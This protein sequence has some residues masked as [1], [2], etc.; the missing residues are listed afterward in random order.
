M[1]K[2][3]L[4]DLDNLVEAEVVDPST[5]EAIRAYYERQREPS[6]NR[7]FVIFGILGAILVGLGIILIIAHNWDQLPRWSKTA[8]AFLPLV[9]GQ[10][11]CVYVLTKRPEDRAWREAATAFLF[12]SVGACLSLVSQI[13]NI[14]G[15]V[16]DFVFTWMLLCWP[17]VYV[18]GSSTASL[19]YLLGITYFGQATGYWRGSDTYAYANWYWLLLLAVVPHYLMQLQKA[20]ESNFTVFHNWIAPLSVVI[21][22][23]IIAQDFGEW[24]FVAYMSWFGI[25]YALGN[26]PIFRE[27]NIWRNGPLV[28]GSLGTM[29]ILLMLSFNWFWEDLNSRELEWHNLGTSVEFWASIAL[30]FL[31]AVLFM[32]TSQRQ[33]FNPISGIFLLFLLVFLTG[34][35]VP[36]LA[37]AVVNI[38]VLMMGVMTIRRGAAADHLGIVNYGLLVI[39][40]L[41]ICRFFDTD[42][43][44]IVRGLLLVSV[45]IG[46]FLT[47]YWLLRRRSE[48]E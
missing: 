27:Q 34:V 33:E 48:H 22:L 13:Y 25:L 21:C 23:G 40:A 19:L 10:G 16:S 46:F 45:G 24:M 35:Y 29:V 30:T 12:F 15:E 39:T 3:L 42:L 14:P 20:P 11:L 9:L 38:L 8:F 17:L 4:K 32:R 37:T 43:S 18:M 47:N 6:Q 7:L 1:N 31:G 28:L 2:K 36:T 41:V 44:F 5:A 26:L